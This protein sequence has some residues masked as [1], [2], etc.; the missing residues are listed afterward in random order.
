MSSADATGAAGASVAPIPQLSD[1]RPALDALEELYRRAHDRVA[2]RV[3][4][5]GRISSK[6]LEQHQLAA[7]ALAYLATETEAARQLAAWAERVGGELELRT[8]GCYIAELCR[9]L[10]G[11][12]DLGPCE[13]IALSQLGIRS[14]DVAETLLAPAVVAMT[15]KLGSGEAICQLARVAHDSGGYGSLGL[16][17]ETLAAIQAEFRRFS[18]SEVVTIAQDVH[19]KDRLI[20]LELLEKMA[21]LG[22]FGLTIPEQYGGMGLGKVA[23]CLV[24]EELSRGYIGVGS[25]GTRAEIAAELILGGGTEAQKEQ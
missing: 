20:P 6:R 17:D 7:H 2:E 24:T 14:A 3:S 4:D 13:S 23:M 11:G 19:R 25:L 21:S 1:L 8:A 15:E 18:E 10:V 22:V 9:Q 12:V 16:G 5:A